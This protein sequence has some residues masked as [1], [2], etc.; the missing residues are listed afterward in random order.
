[1]T[2][3][4]LRACAGQILALSER[5]YRYAQSSDWSGLS[6]LET[7]RQK[8]LDSLFHH[9]QMPDALEHVADIL[10]QVMELDGKSIALG[11]SARREMSG[12][13]D[14]GRRGNELVHIYRHF[15]H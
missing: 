12:K 7:E 2:T 3:I 5:M 1:M 15:E 11:E 10:E 14:I 8:L 9:P 6:I 4:T 13:L